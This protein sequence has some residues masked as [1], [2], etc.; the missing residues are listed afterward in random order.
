MKDLIELGD[1]PIRAPNNFDLKAPRPA[2]L[3]SATRFEVVSSSSRFM[4]TGSEVVQL[5]GG[6]GLV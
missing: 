4:N 5:L 3:A 2:L 6:Q 1:Y